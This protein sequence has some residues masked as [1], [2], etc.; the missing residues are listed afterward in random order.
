MN[1]RTHINKELL[2][3]HM[4]DLLKNGNPAALVL[5]HKSYCRSI[6]WL[7]KQLIRDEF[8]IESLVQ[9]TFLRLWVHR[10]TIETPKHIYFFLRFV[11]RR[12]CVSY[13]TRPK[14]KFTRDIHSL[15]GFED[16]QKYM[17][18]YDPSQNSEHLRQQ[19]EEQRAFDH[20]KSILP[21]LEPKR[22]R[23]IELCLQYGFQYKP[24]AQAMGSNVPEVSWEIRKAI[25]DIKYII[26]QGS[27]FE[28]QQKPV[29]SMKLQGSITEEQAEI[30]KMRCENK[31]SFATIA[32]ELNLSQK[33]V[34][35]A[36]MKAYKLLQQKNE[37]QLKSA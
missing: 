17:A 28:A 26:N 34:H 12:E 2:A 19:E 20:V 4:F 1:A 35:S 16:Y 15:D 11:M 14:N 22:K 5:I 36:F 13:Y 21:L 3:Q 33:E 9:D 18:G 37:E 27:K 7:G 31:L 30:L 24:I 25:E 29:V 8:V 6:F 10:D 32:T 23:L